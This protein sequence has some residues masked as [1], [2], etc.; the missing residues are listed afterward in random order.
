VLVR[1]EGR[2]QGVGFRAWAFRE[3]RA[4]G[5]AGWVRNEADGAVTAHIQGSQENVERMLE[6]LRTGPPG[7]SVTKLSSEPDALE[8]EGGGFRI[9][10]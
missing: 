6:R 4:L 2:V 3:A 9:E 5:L 10:R 8:E 7:A 1:I